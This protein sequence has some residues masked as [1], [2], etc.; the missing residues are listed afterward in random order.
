MNAK[1]ALT[2][3]VVVALVTLATRALPFLLFRGN[4]TKLKFILYLGKVLPPAM[5]GML[6]IYCL[7]AVTPQAYPFGLPE[8]ISIAAVAVLQA[9]KSHTLLSIGGGTILYMVLVQV[10]FV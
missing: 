5:M 10:V 4:R 6:V 8:I 9:W 2:V 3:L 7:K 1:W